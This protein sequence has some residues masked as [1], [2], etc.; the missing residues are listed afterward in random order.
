[1]FDLTVSGVQHGTATVTARATD[2]ATGQTFTATLNVL[3][4]GAPDLNDALNVEGG[5][6]SFTS[7]GTYPWVVDME[8]YP[9]RV[10]ARSTNAG[11]D[12]TVSTVSLSNLHMDQGD[13]LSFDWYVSCETG[14]D[15]L[16][17]YVNGSE[18]TYL[19]GSD[20][21]WL[22]Y[23]FTAQAAGNYS[24]TWKYDKD[25]M[26]ADGMDC[27]WLDDVKL[28]PAG[29]TPPAYTL[30][31]VDNNGAVDSADA[32]LTLRYAMGLT[33]LSDHALAAADVDGNGTVD[34]ADALTILRYAMGLI[35]GF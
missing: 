32:L 13:V 10:A 29:E 27:A 25:L 23:S 9:G 5:T 35:S 30:G 21:G 6:L 1:M 33:S 20:T 26:I 15:Y 24:F 12:S 34:S 7:S 16:R 2:R 8:S 14:F 18:I 17:F 19:T 31:D 3:V 11:H 22:S 4:K 28:T